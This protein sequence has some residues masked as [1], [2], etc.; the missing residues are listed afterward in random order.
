MVTPNCHR[1]AANSLA[2]QGKGAGNSCMPR[3]ARV[4][5]SGY[6]YH[7]LNRGNGQAWVFHDADGSLSGGRV[8]FVGWVTAFAVGLTRVSLRK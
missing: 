1:A 5:V 4:S 8:R 2:A 7:A 3:T 6:C